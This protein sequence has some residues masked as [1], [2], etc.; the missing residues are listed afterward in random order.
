MNVSKSRVSIGLISIHIDITSIIQLKAL[1][2]CKK[3]H[4]FNLQNKTSFGAST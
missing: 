1:F 4:K 2:L 3:K